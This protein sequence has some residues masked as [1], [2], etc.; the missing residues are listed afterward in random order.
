MPSNHQALLVKHI[1]FNH[2]NNMVIDQLTHKQ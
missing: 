2:P 1:N